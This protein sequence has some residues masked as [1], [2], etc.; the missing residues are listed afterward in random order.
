MFALRFAAYLLAF[1]SFIILMPTVRNRSP[2]A[3]L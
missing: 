2:Q 3:S 1:A